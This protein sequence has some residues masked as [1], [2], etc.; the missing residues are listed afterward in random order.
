[1]SSS[2][3]LP[4]TGSAMPPVSLVATN[5]TPQMSLRPVG[6]ISPNMMLGMAMP[7]AGG[8]PGEAYMF[9][10]THSGTSPRS[11]IR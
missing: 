11:V 7:V 8:C 4:G 1:M 6:V 2:R 5:S 3:N 9:R 10:G